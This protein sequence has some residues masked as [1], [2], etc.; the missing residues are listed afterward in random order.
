VWL[1]LV[2]LLCLTRIFQKV[3]RAY[4]LLL[5]EPLFYAIIYF[6]DTI[7][8]L[9]QNFS[10]SLVIPGQL[11]FRQIFFRVRSTL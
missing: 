2:D 6:F 10:M 11:W 7:R 9:S 3:L 8:I 4:P 5:M 1:W